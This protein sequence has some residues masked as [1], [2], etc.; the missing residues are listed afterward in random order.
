MIDILLLGKIDAK[1]A[2]PAPTTRSPFWHELRH[3]LHPARTHRWKTRRVQYRFAAWRH[4][5]AGTDPGHLRLTNAVL[6]AVAVL[7]STTI[8]WL[9][10]H[11]THADHG[12]LA[13][14]GFMALQMGLVVKDPTN[15]AR[16][17]TTALLPIPIAIALTAAVLLGHWR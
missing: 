14:G 3:A 9:L 13:M 8:A 11:F 2:R 16:L 12:L 5:L 6:V 1:G 4:W 15:R 10:V 17:I 7:L